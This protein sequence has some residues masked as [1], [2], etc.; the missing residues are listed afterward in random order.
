MKKIFVLGSGRSG[1]SLMMGVL[2]KL[3]Y[4]MGDN[5]YEPRFANPKGFFESPD[6]NSIN[7]FILSR[8]VPNRPIIF[9]RFFK[10][11]PENGHRWLSQLPLSTNVREIEIEGV[12]SKI[13]ELV[14]RECFLY[15]DPRFSYTLPVWM[16]FVK[17]PVLIIVVF[18]DPIVTVNSILKECSNALYLKDNFKINEK[19]AFNVW[20]LMYKHI[21]SYLD[22]TKGINGIKW[23]FVHYEEIL[24][25]NL[26]SKFKFLSPECL[27]TGFVDSSL[28]RSNKKIPN[29]KLPAEVKE[30]YYKLCELAK[31][32]VNG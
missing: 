4:Y 29:Y 7:E 30:I 14:S 24:H 28:Y 22:E 26:K 17:K 16:K 31:F 18:R 12:E 11:I 27:N 25:S 6:I 5:L 19:R 10:S 3:G 15:K 9:K 32:D 2:S 13:E 21:L 20:K 8:V 1:T 23:L